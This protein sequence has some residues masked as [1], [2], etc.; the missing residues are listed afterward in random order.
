MD[1]YIKSSRVINGKAYGKGE[2]SGVDESLA[3]HLIKHGF[4][5]LVRG[6]EVRVSK[7]VSKPVSKKVEHKKAK[8]KTRAKPKAKK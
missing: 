2:H 3:F 4:A 5:T 8:P 6:E 1:I 7:P